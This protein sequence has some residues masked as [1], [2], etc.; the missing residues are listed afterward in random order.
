MLVKYIVYSSLS[1]FIFR[2]FLRSHFFHPLHT[3]THTHIRTHSHRYT[4]TQLLCIFLFSLHLSFR[5]HCIR[6]DNGPKVRWPY[7][8]IENKTKSRINAFFFLSALC[9]FFSMGPVCRYNCGV[10]I[11]CLL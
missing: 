11:F 5:V 2:F 7:I 8:Q 6:K 4:Q 3:D 9:F 10:L 1:H